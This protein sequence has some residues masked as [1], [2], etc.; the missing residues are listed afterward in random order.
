MRAVIVNEYGGTPVVAEIPTPQ[1]GSHQVL[2][3]VRA[4]AIN[5]IDR[6]VASGARRSEAATFPMVLGADGAG[7]V[8]MV[9]EGETR[10]SPGDRV[11]G[12]LWRAAPL[13]P[14]GTHAEYVAVSADGPL[15]RVPDGLDFV[16]A[17]ALP[18][19]GMTGLALV[20]ALTPPAGKTVLIVG[21]G[22]GVGAF[23]TQFAVA[24]GARV[25]A[26][27]RSDM[28]QR[29]R[30]YGAAETVDHTRASPAD[31]VRQAHPDGID[32][33]IDLASDAHGFSA[34][35]SL[36]RRGGSALTTQYVADV[37]A[38]KSTGVTGIN[39]ALQPSPA[40][41]ERL[42]NAV[43]TGQIVAPPITRVALDQVPALLSGAK[44]VPTDGKTVITL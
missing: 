10:F 8:E 22:G 38:L 16:V 29:L 39:F 11:F 18:I 4:S 12:T 27:V 36:V 1:P 43:V 44:S 30:G 42:A 28:A 33:L 14:A 2:I 21:A 19:A 7:I 37:E 20:E 32:V 3:K 9:G 31:A 6:W 5:P 24:A 41:L 35:A 34:L 15:V 17:A 13:V 23:A 40:L 26:T 25:I